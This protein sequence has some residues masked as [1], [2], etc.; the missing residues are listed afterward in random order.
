M[1][2]FVVY[3]TSVKLKYAP[4]AQRRMHVVW[5]LL[6][7]CPSVLLA[8]SLPAVMLSAQCGFPGDHSGAHAVCHVAGH[9]QNYYK[10]SGCNSL[11]FCLCKQ[12][13]METESDS[14]RS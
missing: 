9:I 7:L 11:F 14:E 2:Y 8:P 12:V 1:N 6:K 10:A 5:C 13:N 4:L 3:L